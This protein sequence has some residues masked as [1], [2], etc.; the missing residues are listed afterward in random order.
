MTTGRCSTVLSWLMTFW[1]L[2]ML[3]VSSKQDC[4]ADFCASKMQGKWDVELQ[5]CSQRGAPSA[6]LSHLS[7]RQQQ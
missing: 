5:L 6:P 2:L 3:L 7:F 1:M 4:A